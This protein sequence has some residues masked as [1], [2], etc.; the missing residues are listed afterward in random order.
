MCAKIRHATREEAERHRAGLA[1]RDRRR[2]FAARPG[3]LHVYFCDQCTCYHVG[4]TRKRRK[5]PTQ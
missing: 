5:D 4:H 1:E 2:G 3:R